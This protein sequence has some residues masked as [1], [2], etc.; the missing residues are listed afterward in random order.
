[1]SGNGKRPPMGAEKRYR[2]APKPAET[3]P[4]RG[5][6]RKPPARRTAAPRSL[7]GRVAGFFGGILR[8]CLR[9]IWGFSLRVGLVTALI[10]ERGVAPASEAGLR[11]LYGERA[12][13]GAGRA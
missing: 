6:R 9:L 10:T 1:M 13:Q 7:L 4:A 5:S 11:G 8:W 3:P 12:L 2:A